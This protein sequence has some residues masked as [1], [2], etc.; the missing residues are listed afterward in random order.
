MNRENI[1]FLFPFEKISCGSDIILYGAGDCG[2]QFFDQILSTDYCKVI[3]WVDK[4]AKGS[5]AAY[6]N[7]LCYPVCVTSIKSIADRKY[8]YLVIAIAK[9]DIAGEA[10]VEL[11][12]TYGVQNEKIIACV[13]EIR[14]PLPFA[15]QRDEFFGRP[16][17]EKELVEIAPEAFITHKRLD[18]M[19]RYLVCAD[20]V[21]GIENRT[22]LSLYSRMLLC[23]GSIYEGTHYFQETA[24]NT[25]KDFIEEVKKMCLSMKSNGFD[26]SCYIPMAAENHITWNGQHR[27]SAALA[28]EKN[29]WVR[30][31]PN[32]RANEDFNID[33]FVNNGFCAYDRLEILRTFAD[34]YQ[35]CGIV[36][37]WGTVRDQWEY[38]QKQFAKK[39]TLVG[40]ADLDF[41][42]NYIAFENLLHEIYSDP[43]WRDVY[44]DRKIHLLKMSPLRIRV[45]LFSD[46]NDKGCD[47]FDILKSEKESLRHHVY[48]ETDIAPVVLHSSDSISEYRNLKNIL[49]NPNNIRQFE[50]RV[51][52]HY[53]EEFISRI[54]EVKAECAKRGIDTD[55]VVIVGSSTLE[56]FGLRQANDIDIAVHSRHRKEADTSVSL[57]WTENIHYARKNS[58]EDVNGTVYPDDLIIEDHNLHY[59]FHGLKFI[60]MELLKMKKQHDRREN[61][62]TDL[63]L[64]EIFEDYCNNF[65]DK[66]ILGQQI[67]RELRQKR[68]GNG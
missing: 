25:T 46:E 37:L 12:Q 53:S 19:V 26:K 60:N 30:Y 54:G 58:I 28:L 32:H 29:I 27:L 64:I 52:R 62:K 49:L 45:M 38:L 14:R 57:Q 23:R 66:H 51:S 47:L 4:W 24:R 20:F 67:E 50:K 35:N 22:H 65:D 36:V 2:R 34:L 1:R 63:R 44:M 33:F 18:T 42:H 7:G 31:L 39:L 8:D 59:M 15:K 6:S 41:S 48:F 40:Y 17:L 43:L 21:R 9:A 11:S 3:L 55:D 5:Q 56:V 68:Y 61:D 10:A 16:N 13:H